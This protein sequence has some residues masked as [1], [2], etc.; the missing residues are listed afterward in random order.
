MQ[1]TSSL[2][3]VEHAQALR[4]VVESRIEA[5]VLRLELR[6]LLDAARAAC[7]S[8]RCNARSSARERQALEAEVGGKPQ[9]QERQPDVERAEEDLA[10]ADGDVEMALEHRRIDLG[11]AR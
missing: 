9:K 6:L 4:H 2:L 11:A 5:Q 7:A 3:A 8:R 10:R 1:T